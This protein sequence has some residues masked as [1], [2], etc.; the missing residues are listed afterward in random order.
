MAHIIV[1]FG[2][3]AILLPSVMAL[4]R[5]AVRWRFEERFTAT[6]MAKDYVRV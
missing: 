4:D 5:R 6:R 3:Y 1:P 2:T